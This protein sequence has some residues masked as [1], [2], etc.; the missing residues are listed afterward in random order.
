MHRWVLAFF[1]L[2]ALAL[3]ASAQWP[4]TEWTVVGEANQDGAPIFDLGLDD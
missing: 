2:I 4:T 3:S 1:V